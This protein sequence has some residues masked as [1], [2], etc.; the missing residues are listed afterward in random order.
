MPSK[1]KADKSN[2]PAQ[3]EAPAFDLDY[4]GPALGLW[5][6]RFSRWW[7]LTTGEVW[8]THNP[9]VAAAQLHNVLTTASGGD[10]IIRPMP[11]PSADAA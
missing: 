6:A 7:S 10:W 5:S 3:P 8:H 9:E 2:P 1:N 4:V 11:L